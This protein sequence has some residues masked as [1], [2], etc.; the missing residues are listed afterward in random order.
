MSDEIRSRHTKELKALEG[1]KRAELKKAKG[2]S[3]K[4]QKAKEI[5]AK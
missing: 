2:T 4:G 5:L 1:E 3:G